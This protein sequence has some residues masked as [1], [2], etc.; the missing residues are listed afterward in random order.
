MSVKMLIG[1]G[2]KRNSITWSLTAYT[3]TFHRDTLPM[4]PLLRRQ[5]N[6]T[7][8]TGRV[9]VGMLHET[10]CTRYDT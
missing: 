4:K 10:R 3:W 8:Q 1:I 6:E 5:M 7:I 2:G 9:S